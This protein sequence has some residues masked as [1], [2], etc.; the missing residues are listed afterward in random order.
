MVREQHVLT[1]IGRALGHY[2]AVAGRDKDP[3]VN[4]NPNDGEQRVHIQLAQALIEACTYP[5]LPR[6]RVGGASRAVFP[7]ECPT[8]RD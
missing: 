5:Y 8:R 2:L 4:A 3:R 1:L 7:E 6:D